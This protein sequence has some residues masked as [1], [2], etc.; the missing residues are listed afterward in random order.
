MRG[1]VTEVPGPESRAAGAALET[2]D[3]TTMD[4]LLRVLRTPSASS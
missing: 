2:Q 4:T 3:V 1:S